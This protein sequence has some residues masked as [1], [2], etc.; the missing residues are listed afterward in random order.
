M[1][2]E[3]WYK[4]EKVFN[5]EFMPI[6]DTDENHTPDL[7]HLFSFKQILLKCKYEKEA[8]I[9][10]G[11]LGAVELSNRE[12]LREEKINLIIKEVFSYMG[13]IVLQIH[14]NVNQKQ[15]IPIKF[16]QES[17]KRISFLEEIL[18]EE[19]H[20]RKKYI[21]DWEKIFKV[22]AEN[23]ENTEVLDPNISSISKKCKIHYKKIQRCFSDPKFLAGLLE[24]LLKKKNQAKKET[25]VLLW[26]DAG[27]VITQKLSQ[28][29]YYGDGLLSEYGGNK[30]ML[31][32]RNKEYNDNYNYKDTHKSK[33]RK[34][35][36]D[37][38]DDGLPDQG[39]SSS[40]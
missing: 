10:A 40:F 37:L 9:F 5:D 3:L 15:K 28:I 24:F 1:D 30:V 6:L 32:G 11:I 16:I 36:S 39:F 12:G 25:K 4:V 29:H 35:I 17:K 34:N 8:P 14:N 26:R 13:L 38:D 23:I 2:S 20:Q 7:I 27:I 21:S 33:K 18:K 22:Y 19:Y 31:N